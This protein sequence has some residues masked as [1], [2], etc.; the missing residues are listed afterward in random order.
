VARADQPSNATLSEDIKGFAEL[1]YMFPMLF[2]GAAAV[3]IYV[4]LTRRVARDRAFIGMLRANGFRRRTIL[5]HYLATGL[6]V[7]AAGAIPGVAAGLLLAGTITRVYTGAI[8]IPDTLVSVRVTTVVGGLAFGLVAGAL[9]ALAP[10][11]AASRIPP[12]EAMRGMVP[13]GRGG[14]GILARLERLAP[15]T[16]R[17]P[18]GAWLVLRGPAR[19]PRRTLYTE[20]GVVLA[21]VLILVSWGMLDTSNATLSRQ[22]DRIQR[23]DAELTLD[24]QADAA[25]LAQLSHRA[26]VAAAEPAAQVPVAIE[27][28]PHTYSTAL[29]GLQ[30]NTTMHTFLIPD[31][32]TRPLPG[33]GLLLGVAMRDKLHLNVG[34]RVNLHLAP[35]VK[36]SSAL[37]RFAAG[38]DRTAAA[39]AL[40]SQP[41]VIAYTDARALQKT[42]R[43][44]MRLF[45]VFVA[46]MLVFGGLL[47][48]T[49]L[50]A[51]MSV[52]IAE[53]GVEHA[54]LRASGVSRRRLARLVTIE[55]LLLVALG[56]VPGLFIGQMA[57]RAFLGA[58]N[59][60]LFA[61]HTDIRPATFLWAALAVIVVA[62]LA[63]APGLRVLAR[64]DLASIVRERAS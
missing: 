62:P 55:N 17:L 3:S 13:S 31:N 60:D 7:G 9:A 56:I 16:R 21:L 8:G 1:A 50:F 52:N 26:G 6:V 29:I 28:G 46:V 34:D 5:G 54:T 51:T 59:S 38:A 49:V 30:P 45:Y 24:H 40:K 42:A 57:T 12:A 19:Q 53:R 11:V 61:F 64:L 2:L 58:F 20:F 44:F 15:V 47:A 33:E 10:A 36:P 43:D 63:Q 41:G 14:R 22:F 32:D 27:K 18:A 39:Q 48:F 23:Q 25:T 4:V 35:K 37:V